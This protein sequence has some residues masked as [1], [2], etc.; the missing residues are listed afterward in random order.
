MSCVRQCWKCIS[1]SIA[2]SYDGGVERGQRNPAMLRL[3]HIAAAL[4]V[5]VGE[6]FADMR[7]LK[8]LLE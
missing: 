8:K 1:G 3:V 7:V 6:L 2:R 4:D 5:E